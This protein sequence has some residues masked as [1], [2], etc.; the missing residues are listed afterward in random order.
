MPG[1]DGTRTIVVRVTARITADDGWSGRAFRRGYRSQT[2][3]P[4]RHRRECGAF[5]SIE[6]H[7]KLR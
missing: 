2:Y 1:S 3:R 5:V 7:E 6:T 4:G